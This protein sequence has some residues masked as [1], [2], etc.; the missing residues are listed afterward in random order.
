MRAMVLDKPRTPLRLTN[1]PIP[2]PGK[3]EIL[4]KI[5]TCAVCRTDL[6]IV[7]GELNQAKQQVVPG[8]QIVGIVEKLGEGV[9]SI[10]AGQ[11]VGVPWLGETCGHCEFCLDGKENLC[12]EAKYT[13]YQINGGFAE[14]CLAKANF[15]FFIPESYPDLQ[16]APLLCGGLIGYRALGMAKNSKRIGFYGFGSSAHIIIQVSRYL[17][18]EIFTFT[19]K[20]DEAAQSL[21]KELGSTWVGDS[22]QIA[23][24]PLDAAIIFAPV[25]SLVPAALKAV[26]KGGVVICA[27][28]HM[29]D[30]PSFPYSL[31]WGER[32]VRSVANLT[33]RDGQELLALAPK[34]PIKTKVNVYCLEEANQALD[35]LREGK[36][37]G[38]AVIKL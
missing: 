17:N 6:H 24:V 11:R 36:I 26:K 15:T 23:P 10:R 22:E 4:I 32:I 38:T 12:D 34:I 25:G 20:G 14:Y 30:I 16:A 21:A 35:D 33:R 28:I 29:S 13:G 3:G 5:H 31:L 8:H 1:L 9:S 27:G 19:R 7:D 18:Q 37:T 2:R